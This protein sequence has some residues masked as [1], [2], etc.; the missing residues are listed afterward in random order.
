V[1]QLRGYPHA[2]SSKRN[3]AVFRGRGFIARY[4]SERFC[5]GGKGQVFRAQTSGVAGKVFQ[6]CGIAPPPALRSC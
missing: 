3:A 6:A 4:R 2:V 1:F 5:I